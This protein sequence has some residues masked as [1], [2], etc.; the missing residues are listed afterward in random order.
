MIDLFDLC[1]TQILSYCNRNTILHCF[2]FFSRFVFSQKQNG[3]KGSSPTIFNQKSSKEKMKL[4]NRIKAFLNF[5][6]IVE[7]SNFEVN[8]KDRK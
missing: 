2:A 5:D 6:L 3:K 4:Y 7:V 8:Q 1:E